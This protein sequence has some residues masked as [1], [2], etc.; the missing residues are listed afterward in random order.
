MTTFLTLGLP[1]I[2]FNRENPIHR[3]KSYLGSGS[4]SVSE[5]GS[6]SIITD[7]DP[8]IRICIKMIRIRNT[9]FL[10]TWDMSW[11]VLDGLL[12]DED[13]PGPG[14]SREGGGGAV[15]HSEWRV[16]QLCPKN[17]SSSYKLMFYNSLAW[18]HNA[19]QGTKNYSRRLPAHSLKL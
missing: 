11:S 5:S 6:G 7:A 19:A 15:E 1:C 16:W 14:E 13:S 2:T 12:R 10:S 18:E 9:D 8:R 17:S 4:G 3:I